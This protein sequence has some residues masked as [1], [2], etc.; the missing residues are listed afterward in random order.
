MLDR[1]RT[2]IAYIFSHVRHDV[3]HALFMAVRCETA[4]KAGEGQVARGER[5]DIPP[6]TPLAPC[7]SPEHR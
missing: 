5:E 7:L 3:R 4:W 2:V 6:V 1:L